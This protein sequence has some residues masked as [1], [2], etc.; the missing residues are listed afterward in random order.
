[1]SHGCGVGVCTYVA[2]GEEV[3]REE[4]RLVEESRESV[5]SAALIG[6]A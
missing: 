4:P 3:V 1:M 6:G 2:Q 5:A